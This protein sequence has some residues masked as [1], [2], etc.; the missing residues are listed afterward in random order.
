MAPTDSTE[1][2][3]FDLSAHEPVS[4]ITEQIDRIM[5]KVIQ[6]VIIAHGSLRVGVAAHRLKLAVAL[7]LIQ[8]LCDHRPPQVCVARL[9][10]SR[11][12]PFPQRPEA[13][14]EEI[15]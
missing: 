6:M 10:S 8:G 11:R 1:C 12:V 5:I 15:L 7:P 4:I 14:G 2:F 13:Q 9:L 3:I